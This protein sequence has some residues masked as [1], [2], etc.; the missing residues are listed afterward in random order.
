MVNVGY[1][2]AY[3]WS[4]NAWIQN[5]VQEE[6]LQF[7]RVSVCPSVKNVSTGKK[8]SNSDRVRNKRPQ[9]PNIS[10]IM[11]LLFNFHFFFFF[12]QTLAVH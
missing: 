8:R 3:D 4:E 10:F 6:N 9:Q 1:V 5:S 11:V 7:A 12:I 2:R